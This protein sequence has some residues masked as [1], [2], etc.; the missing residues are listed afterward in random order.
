MAKRRKSGKKRS[1]SPAQRAALARGRAALRARRGKKGI[2]TKKQARNLYK[3]YHLLGSKQTTVRAVAPTSLEPIIIKGGSIM[4]KRKK[5]R[6]ARKYSGIPV[7]GAKRR[8]S[9]SRRYHGIEGRRKT[10]ARRY[11]GAA[12]LNIV[13][14]VTDI[15]GVGAGAV[16]GSFIAQKIPVK[17]AKIK[18]LIPIALGL[19][20]GMTKFGRGNLAKSIAGGMIAVGTLSLVKQFFPAVPLLTGAEDAESV[21]GAIDNLPADER[22]LL[23]MVVQGEDG[24]VME[25]PETYGYIDAPLSPD[26]I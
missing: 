25:S 10:R 12:K 6:K 7:A 23:G 15:V 18:A 19:G 3:N 5:S 13:G 17:N 14:L 11:H 20:L 8:T 21:A 4:A 9:K 1:L 2:G 26:N 16:G 22:A 24:E